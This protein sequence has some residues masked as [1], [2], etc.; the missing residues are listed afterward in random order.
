MISLLRSAVYPTD[1]TANGSRKQRLVVFTSVPSAAPVEECTAPLGLELGG[2]SPGPQSST[3]SHSPHREVDAGAGQRRLW[4]ISSAPLSAEWSWALCPPSFALLVSAPG[5]FTQDG[6]SYKCC[7]SGQLRGREWGG[8]SRWGR[9]FLS[10]LGSTQPCTSLLAYRQSKQNPKLLNWGYVE[11]QAGRPG[12]GAQRL[13]L[14]H[15]LHCQPLGRCV[16]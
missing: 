8:G 14:A 4:A 10:P 7:L 12:A 5:S 9:N 16:T 11:G 2:G 6:R 3:A 15:Q 13:R 1:R